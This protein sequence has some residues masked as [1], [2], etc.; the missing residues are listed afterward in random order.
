MHLHTK[1][2]IFKHKNIPENPIRLNMLKESNVKI[3]RE[4]EDGAYAFLPKMILVSY[5][6]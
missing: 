3:L 5:K 4:K 1:C 6:L 2:V